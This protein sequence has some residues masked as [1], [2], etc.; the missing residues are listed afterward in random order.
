MKTL[1][2]RIKRNY[3]DAILSGKK[4]TET[5]EVKPATAT[6]YIYFTHRGKDYRRQ[7]DIP[8]DEFPVH[9]TPVHYDRLLLING[10][11]ADAPRLTVE[12]KD[13]NFFFLTDERDEYIIQPD[14]KGEEYLAAI[15]EYKLGQII[16][17]E[18]VK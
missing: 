4:T 9:I 17:A 18:N 15:V 2:L 10:Y 14:E 8:R 11:H 12:V 5:R 6:R 7:R 13:A 16:N 3:F 1:T